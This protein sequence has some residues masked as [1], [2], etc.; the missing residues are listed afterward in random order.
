MLVFFM[1]KS[2]YNTQFSKISLSPFSL[3]NT[4]ATCYINPKLTL[5]TYFS[6]NSESMPFS[7]IYVL[8]AISNFLCT[9]F[10]RATLQT[11]SSFVN[12]GGY[13]LIPVYTCWSCC[14]E[15]VLASKHS[16]R[17]FQN[18][19]LLKICY[20]LLIRFQNFVYW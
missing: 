13:F 5:N 16:P 15:D 7:G 20:K 6:L 9:F 10:G 3:L 1:T 12:V 8:Q 18:M 4:C 11:K 14:V 17:S 19:L 2:N